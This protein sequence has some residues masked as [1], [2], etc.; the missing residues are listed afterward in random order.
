[1]LIY[2]LM[3]M[4]TF[5]RLRRAPHPYVLLFMLLLT[6]ELCERRGARLEFPVEFR[7]FYLTIPR[8][9]PVHSAGSPI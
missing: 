4:L 2:V 6:K 5:G 7:Q 8:L 9:L 3:L 1:M